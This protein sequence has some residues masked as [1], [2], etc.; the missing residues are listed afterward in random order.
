MGDN[1]TTGNTGSGVP[2]WPPPRIPVMRMMSFA[3]GGAAVI[4][5]F[6]GYCKLAAILALLSLVFNLWD[7]F[8]GS[9]SGR[10]NTRTPADTAG[11]SGTGYSGGA[12]GPTSTGP[13][14]TDKPDR[15]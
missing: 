4:A 11:A 3:L 6:L 5:G 8:Q 7:F 1:N 9:G 12:P 10:P 14:R 15:Y 13:G 2:A